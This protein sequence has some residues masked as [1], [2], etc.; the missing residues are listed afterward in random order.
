MSSNA[1]PS[2]QGPEPE[3]ALFNNLKTYDDHQARFL[4]TLHD[5]AE[6]TGSDHKIG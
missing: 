3:F 5:E 2:L 4:V 1:D 6:L